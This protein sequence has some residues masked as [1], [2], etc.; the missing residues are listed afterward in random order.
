MWETFVSFIITWISLCLISK[1]LGKGLLATKKSLFLAALSNAIFGAIFRYAAY[2]GIIYSPIKPHP[3]LVAAIAFSITLLI[4]PTFT[5]WFADK[6]IKGFKVRGRKYFSIA[7]AWF[8]LIGI[9]GTGIVGF[10]P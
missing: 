8:V 9:I 4:L 6:F 7:C 2:L 5:F 1:I 3:L 10:M